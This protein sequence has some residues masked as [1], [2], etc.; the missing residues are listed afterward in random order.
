MVRQ[1]KVLNFKIWLCWQQHEQ[2]DPR[3]TL[4][5]IGDVA[6][7]RP[8][9]PA[10]HASLRSI[11]FNNYWYMKVW[12]HYGT[13]IGCTKPS[14]NTDWQLLG[15]TNSFTNTPVATNKLSVSCM[16]LV[17]IGSGYIRNWEYLQ[18]RGV[19]LLERI[20]SLDAGGPAICLGNCLVCHQ[21]AVT[22]ATIGKTRAEISLVV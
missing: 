1:R 6:G 9:D 19:F 17:H 21:C 8:D 4:T 22:L 20:R 14:F 11:I 7:P 12:Q 3:I 5:T 16:N 18:T 10:D 15:T 13:W 2:W